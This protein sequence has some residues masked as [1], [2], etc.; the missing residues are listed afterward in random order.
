MREPCRGTLFG[1][2][3]QNEQ[4]HLDGRRTSATLGSCNDY[5]PYSLRHTLGEG[6]RRATSHDD[7][8]SRE[9]RHRWAGHLDEM[10]MR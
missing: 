4:A 10:T 2:N 5:G 3:P 7:L 1:P 6:L 8:K 9:L